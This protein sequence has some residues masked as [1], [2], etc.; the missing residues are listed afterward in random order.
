MP[1]ITTAERV[2][3]EKGIE[4]SLGT[5]QQ[6]LET[7]LELKFGLPAQ[8]LKANIAQIRSLE[9]L[10]ALM[11]QLQQTQSLSEAEALFAH[12]GAQVH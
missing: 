3:I 11:Q 12:V 5:V 2:G 4:K 9:T 8:R 7:I 10:Q 1:H 6:A